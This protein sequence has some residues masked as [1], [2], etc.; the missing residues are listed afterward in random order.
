LEKQLAHESYTAFPE[1]DEQSPFR[2]VVWQS[3]ASG[4][5][6]LQSANDSAIVVAFRGS[7]L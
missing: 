5:A 1:S 7:L 6:S 4:V 3:R 2:A